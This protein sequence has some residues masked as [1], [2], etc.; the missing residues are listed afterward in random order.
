MVLKQNEI[1]S[2]GGTPLSIRANEFLPSFTVDPN[3]HATTMDYEGKNPA[4]QI[5]FLE[6]GE[7]KAR[8]WLQKNNPHE[9]FQIQADNKLALAAPPPFFLIN[10]D[11]V[12]FSGIQAGF[13]PGA[14]LFWFGSLWLLVGLCMHFYLHQRRLRVEL[15]PYQGRTRVTVIGW[16]SRIPADF[17]RDFLS[18]AGQ[19]KTAL[20]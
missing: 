2:I 1:V 9:A 14:P 16:N 17:D 3:G 15:E 20:Q 4:L 7:V 11:P 19:I 12:L 10:I 13:D 5:D 18:W 8:V 6:Q